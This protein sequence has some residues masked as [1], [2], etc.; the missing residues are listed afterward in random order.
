MTTGS[1]SFL[2][3]VQK[4][5]LKIYSHTPKASAFH[6]FLVPSFFLAGSFAERKT[7]QIV[8]ICPN[9]NYL[10]LKPQ[11]KNFSLGECHVTVI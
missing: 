2:Q 1:T 7:N 8:M 4:L 9:L 10:V 5:F 6:A 3:L 11:E